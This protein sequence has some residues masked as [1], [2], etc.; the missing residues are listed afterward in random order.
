MTPERWQRIKEIFQA[1]R[2]RAPRER[3]AYLAAETAG[4]SELRQEVDKM[5]RHASGTGLFDRPAW[6][7][8]R[9]ENELD[10]GAHLGPYEILEE[11]GAG[12]MGR[13]YKARDTRLGRTVAIKVLSAEFS[14]RLRM[15]G[16]AISALN[17]AHVCALYDI[18][19]QEGYLVMEYVEGESLA[20][21]LARGPL[22]FDA[23]LRYGAEI[24]GALAA[25]HALGIVHRDLKPANI[26][27]T[28]SGAK[29]LD[30][31]VARIVQ[32]EESYGEG[33]AGTAAYMSPSQLNGN[34]ADARSDIFA[35]GL[36]LYEMATGARPSLQSANRMANLPAGLA[37][38]IE[39]CLRQDAGGRVQRMEEVQSALERLRS[40]SARVTWGRRIRPVP[41]A[42]L[43]AM[44]AATAVLT[45]QFIRPVPRQ[46]PLSAL[47]RPATPGDA[48]NAGPRVPAVQP[49][50]AAL[51]PARRST[52]PIVRRALLAPP[53][54]AILASYPGI[55]RDA[56]FSPDGANI[57]FSWHSPVR[58]GYGIYVRPVKSEG[59]PLG[60][61]DG[62]FEDWGPA[63]SPD[64][65]TIAFRRKAGQSGI[66]QVRAAGGPANL[67]A[68]IA[69]QAQETLPQM[70][71]SR[72][73][74]WIAAPDR[75]STGA[76]QIYLFAIGSGEKRA[77]TSN[78]GGTDHAPAFS[79]DGKSL[80]YASC[81]SAVYPCDVYAIDLG[82]D[83]VPKRRR[84]ITEQGVYIRGIAWL[85]DGRSLVYSAGRTV[86]QDT[87]L[88]RVSVNPPGFPERIDMAGSAARHP[89][90]SIRGGF[91][92]YTRLNNWSLMMIQN[93]R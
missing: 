7:G 35:L 72:D 51:S 6:E 52:V 71:W 46:E 9:S 48:R 33:V 14:H 92:A 73:G 37:S 27:I 81:V 55:K 90:I 20:A 57:A 83:F 41:V 78:P 16:R 67:V 56:S 80:A 77:M 75:D 59:P 36:V 47:A 44:A 58:S 49:A 21:C 25:A 85:P 65:G 24:A 82:P 11:V 86:S 1:A 39:R 38:L 70:S 8:L 30:F 18:C 3:D 88:W 22:P 66:Y 29:V 84:R 68:P 87:F 10:R 76:T 60:L 40:E 13:V 19:D 5:L 61:T 12:G 74:K 62:G 28:L 32:D 69:R 42:V 64:G 26:M 43:L 89:A 91:L 79:P 50:A 15:E 45:W 63:W 23:V 54:L 17:H 93:F 53:T 2:D 4:D 31:G 34:P